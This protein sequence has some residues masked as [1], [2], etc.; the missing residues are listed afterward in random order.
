MTFGDLLREWKFWGATAF[1]MALG[2]GIGSLVGN[3]AD[4]R[5][6]ALVIPLVSILL[7]LPLATVIR[8]HW[9][10]WPTAVLVL[11]AHVVCWLLLT[12]GFFGWTDA[13]WLAGEGFSAGSPGGVSMAFA[14]LCCVIAI[15][16][17]VSTLLALALTLATGI[18]QPLAIIG[19]LLG[20][21]LKTA[22]G[23]LL[24]LVLALGGTVVATIAA[25]FIA[26]AGG[27]PVG[28]VAV[29][30]IAL[31]GAAAL[32]AVTAT[33]VVWLADMETPDG[34]TPVRVVLACGAL[35]AA[36]LGLATGESLDYADVSGPLTQVE[37]DSMTRFAPSS[38]QLQNEIRTKRG[39]NGAPQIDRAGTTYERNPM[40]MRSFLLH[41]E[42]RA[43]ADEAAAAATAAGW[44]L[45]EKNDPY[46]STVAYTGTRTQDGTKLQLF[47]S[48]N[49]PSQCPEGS[50]NPF[51]NGGQL[52]VEVRSEW[53]LEPGARDL[54]KEPMAAYVPPGTTAGAS[55]IYGTTTSSRDFYVLKPEGKQKVIDA[56]AATARAAQSHGWQQSVT[57]ENLWVG[58]KRDGDQLL[59]LRISTDLLKGAS[60]TYVDDKE[61]FVKIMIMKVDR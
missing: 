26:F 48:G 42:A 30:V 17:G 7:L 46:S 56:A 45:Q 1:A 3:N 57:G 38:A 41:G 32:A 23:I 50:D 16:L 19:R 43:A 44:Q 6:L 13:K 27:G 60:G 61:G 14:V 24:T 5:T 49:G 20:L 34:P 52:R 51:C 53:A 37:Q 55:Q 40:V 29:P 10:A 12:A 31:A 21:P 36:G 25:I 35:L 39:R 11:A 18:E 59:R 47:I 28:L 8:F 2:V 54:L 9:N 58:E 15:P 22:A 33:N 4:E